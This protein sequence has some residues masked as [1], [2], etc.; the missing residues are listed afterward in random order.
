[1][2]EEALQ[3]YDGTV[4]IV[5]HDRYF[6]SKVANKIVEIR[7]GEFRPYLGDYHYY[8]DKIAEEKEQE[9]QAKIAAE[10]AAKKAAKQAKAGAKSK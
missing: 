9:R 2:L 10:K 8:L 3:N 7:D 4:I 6:I 5:S 1:M